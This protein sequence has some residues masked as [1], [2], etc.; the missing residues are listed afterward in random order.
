[1][2]EDEI[3][4]LLLSAQINAFH[5]RQVGSVGHGTDAQSCYACNTAAKAAAAAVVAHV[6]PNVEAS[7]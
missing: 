3:F 2:S 1:V 6:I 5:L 7:R 4:R